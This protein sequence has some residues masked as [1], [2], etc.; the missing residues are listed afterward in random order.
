MIAKINVGG[1]GEIDV[2]D[3]VKGITESAHL[4]MKIGGRLLFYNKQMVVMVCC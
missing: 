4:R 3:R 2:E 1:G